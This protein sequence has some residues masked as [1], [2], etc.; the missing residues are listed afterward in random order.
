MALEVE[1]ALVQ[2]PGAVEP[3]E[4]RGVVPMV[5]SQAQRGSVRRD[6]KP[7]PKAD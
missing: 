4:V 7:F 1:Q 5:H 2:Q 6:V 3:P